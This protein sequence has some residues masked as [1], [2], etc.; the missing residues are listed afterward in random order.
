MSYVPSQKPDNYLVWSILATLFCCVPTG[1]AAIVF[2]AQ[3][4]SK[5]TAGDYAGA[6]NASEKAKLWS[7]VSFGLGLTFAVLYVLLVG[8]GA[9]SGS[10]A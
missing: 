9:A 8:L 2:A 5:W 6:Q 4:D 10:Y 1:I 3:V 7:W